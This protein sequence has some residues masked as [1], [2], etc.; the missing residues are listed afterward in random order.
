MAQLRIISLHPK[1]AAIFDAVFSVIL[2][3]WMVGFRSP[4]MIGVWFAIRLIWWI[5]LSQFVYYPPYLSR[6]RHFVSLVIYNIGIVPFLI[7]SD[8]TTIR[9]IQFFAIAAPFISFW[10]IPPQADSLSIMVKPHRR[11]K[12]FMSLFGVAGIWLFVEASITFQIITGNLIF[13]SIAIAS[14]LTTAISYWEWKEYSLEA[15]KDFYSMLFVMFLLLLEV[16]AILFLWPVGYF[17]SSFILTWF[18]YVIWLLF[19]FYLSKEGIHWN[20]Q[21]IFIIANLILMI[22]FLTS[23]VRWR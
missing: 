11:W 12:F 7:F 20:Q 5:V 2:L 19:R 21:R 23:F 18:W 3:W 1:L 8:P 22:L 17:I 16:G 10:L 4:S 9:I 13:S 14:L 6:I 15:N